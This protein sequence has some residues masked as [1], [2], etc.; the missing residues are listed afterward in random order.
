M[1]TPES[2]GDRRPPPP[3]KRA[4]GKALCAAIV[5]ALSCGGAHSTEINYR[6]ELE[7]LHSD[8]IN[9]SEDNQAAETVFIPRLMF[10]LRQ[11]G[12]TVRL[13]ARGQFEH[14]YY[15][16]SRFADENRSEFAG[17][18]NWSLLP[19]RLN[20]VFEDYLSE[21]SINLR[22]GRYPGNLQQVNIFLAGPSY[23]ARL[24]DAARFQLD[25]RGADSYAEVSPGFNGRR[26]SAAAAL[27]RDLTPTSKASLN[28]ASTR[29]SFDDAGTVDYT[30]QDGF[31]RYE[32][33]LP[34]I[35][36]QLDLGHSRLKRD[37]PT[38]AS[39]TLARATVQWQITPQS[40]LRL[41][42]RQQFAD[43]VQDLIVRLSDPEEALVPDLV[44][45]ASTLVT[46][47]VYRQRD[48]Q[49]DYRYAG[50][51]FGFR[52]RPMYR[53]FIYIDREDANRTERGVFLQVDY[54]PRPRMNVFLN[55]SVRT[56]DFLSVARAERDVDHV[57]RLGVEY[58]LT[59]HWGWRAEAIKNNR[60]SS[61]PDPVYRENAVQLSAWW[62]R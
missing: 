28:L 4:R 22:E 41:R 34:D 57:Y 7:A 39:T 49:L 18:L 24:G 31:I 50:D 16:G 6:F 27:Q 45:A 3:G 12:A 14:R 55:G 20:L 37:A 44:D 23:F 53:R 26:Y 5:T 42:A 47:G 17:Q 36:Y 1:K 10:D 32:G 33:T 56:R 46:A 19:G 13:E 29:A 35:E 61:Q 40:R 60:S 11:E 25:L 58:Q 15:T 51:R 30:R 2:L 54:H 38:D 8:N 9:L 43:E 59:R 62:K 48:V 21:E 52:L